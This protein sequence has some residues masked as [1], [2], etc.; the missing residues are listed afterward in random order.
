MHKVVLTPETPDDLKEL[1]PFIT[2]HIRLCLV[3]YA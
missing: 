1:Y 3:H 2:E